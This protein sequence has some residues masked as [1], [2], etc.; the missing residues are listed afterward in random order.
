MIYRIERDRGNY[1]AGLAQRRVI[2]EFIIHQFR[3]MVK[4]LGNRL[5]KRAR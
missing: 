1:V 5:E 4:A 2:N 3:V